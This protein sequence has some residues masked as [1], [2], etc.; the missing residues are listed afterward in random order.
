MVKKFAF[1]LRNPWHRTIF[2][3]FLSTF[4][5][6]CTCS[7][8]MLLVINFCQIGKC[9]A[10]VSFTCIFYKQDAN[11][12]YCRCVHFFFRK[13][14]SWKYYSHFCGSPKNIL[15]IC[16][17][18]LSFSRY[19]LWEDCNIGWPELYLSSTLLHFK[20]LYWCLWAVQRKAR[21]MGCI[22]MSL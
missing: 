10:Y 1:G 14:S 18:V 5:W 17:H 20:A 19:V 6:Y 2:F 9:K 7:G 22:K 8:V 11:L 15:E 13:A 4:T 3:K 16:L 12:K 21:L